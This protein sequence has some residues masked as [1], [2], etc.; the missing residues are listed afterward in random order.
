MA[1]RPQSALTALSLVV[2]MGVAACT[3]S[4]DSTP[5]P[6]L[7][8]TTSF[9]EALAPPPPREDGRLPS[10]VRPKSYEIELRVDPQSPDYSGKV[11]IAVDITDS[12]GAIVLHGFDLEIDQAVLLREGMAAALTASN[13]AP[14]GQSEKDELVLSSLVALPAGPATLIINFRGKYSPALRGLYK[15]QDSGLDYVFTQF[16]PN[17]ARRAF[18]CF[19]EPGFKAPTQL[20]L[21]VPKG[22]VAIANASE[23]GHDPVEGGAFTRYRF[24]PTPPIPTYL[25]A[26]GVGQLDVLEGK[27]SKP[28][29]RIVATRGKAKRGA[30]ALDRT[31]ELVAKL[32][33]YFGIEHP[34]A[35]LDVVAVPEFA[36]GAM[37]NPGFVT[38]REELVL[39]DPARATLSDRRRMDAVITHELAHQ[40]FGNLVTARWW[41]DLWLNEGFATWAES[42]GLP[43][44][45]PEAVNDKMGV[46][47]TDVLASA[48]AVRQ[49]VRNNADALEAFD[50]VTYVKGASILSMLEAFAGPE[51]FQAGVRRYVRENARKNA[52]ATEFLS[53]LDEVTGKPISKVASTFLDRTG[54]PL[55]TVDLRCDGEPRVHLSQKAFPRRG[56][57]P[58]AGSSWNVP[59]CVVA[60]DTRQEICTL[61]DSSEKDLPLGKQC[62][63]WVF[64]NANEQGYFRYAIGASGLEKLAASKGHLSTTER[65]GLAGNEWALARGGVEPI[66]EVVRVLRMVAADPGMNSKAKPG[67]T[68]RTGRSKGEVQRDRHVIEAMTNVLGALFE[69]L[70]T[71]AD[72]AA[73][74]ALVKDLLEPTFSHLGWSNDGML[75]SAPGKT[76]SGDDLITVREK[77]ITALALY[78]N[79]TAVQKQARERAD[80][81]LKHDKRVSEENGRLAMRVAARHGDVALFDAIENVALHG[82]TPQDRIAALGALGTFENPTL[83]RRALDLTLKDGVKVQDVRYVYA[84]AV[85]HRASQAVVLSWIEEHYEQIKK[86]LPDYMVGRFSDLISRACT[87]EELHQRDDRLTPKLKGI[88]GSE[89]D[90]MLARETANA[91]IELRSREGTRL[92]EALKR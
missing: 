3:P 2:T 7:A 76:E 16:E 91:C 29:V 40:W 20:T 8:T 68:A 63:S 71:T 87:S 79:D 41:D 88:E 58:L 82:D 26:F 39:L 49:P 33:G 14:G 78:A 4:T 67:I 92:T 54:V 80:A 53:T 9:E 23:L 37:E 13:R 38:F 84:P 72:Q 46:M 18:P 83:L 75:Q 35:K 70:V 17:D 10:T 61:L 55:V 74:A 27:A 73:F 31:R 66:G 60:G 15:M 42:K 47:E 12:V 77:V 86:R 62:P 43:E 19:D 34:F 25:I 28:P 64:P 48:R 59:V 21:D 44:A 56:T 24:E 22:N 45:A 90:L 36:A 57:S 5:T 85:A 51:K 11:S 52:S 6:R 1:A 89:R 50:N 69:D 30:V 65:V 32:E 81:Y